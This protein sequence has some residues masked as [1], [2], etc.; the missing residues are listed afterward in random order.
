MYRDRL[1]IIAAIACLL[2]FTSISLPLC[3]YL[4]VL[5]FPAMLVW[6]GA[7]E[8]LE[9]FLPAVLGRFWKSIHDIHLSRAAVAS[10]AL[11]ILASFFVLISSADQLWDFQIPPTPEETACYDAQIWARDHT[12]REAAFLVPPE[13][14]GFRILSQRSSWGEWSDGNAMYFDPAF[15]NTFLKRVAV[16][17]QAPVP[18]GTAI[19]DSLT[20]KYKNEPWDRIRAVA[21]ENKL[22]YIVQFRSTQ[23][24]AEPAYSNATFAIYRAR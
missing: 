9:R 2:A 13:G 1:V 6:L 21:S 19:I 17:D 3:N 18:E 8:R 14:C 24:P 12:P 20:E 10:C 4:T 5:L 16:L 15:A 22:D 23:Y 11:G 7:G